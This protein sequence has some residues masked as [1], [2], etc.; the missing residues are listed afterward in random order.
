MAFPPEW[1][2]L[3]TPE[4]MGFVAW[5][6]SPDR[7]GSDGS[8]GLNMAADGIYVYRIP[9][10]ERVTVTRIVT[11]FPYLLAGGFVANSGNRLGLYTVT[12][13]RIVQS[14][15]MAAT[16]PGVGVKTGV[17][18]PTELTRGHYYVAFGLDV[19]SGGPRLPTQ[20]Y[21][22]NLGLRGAGYGLPANQP[23]SGVT[24]DT[25]ADMVGGLPVQFKLPVAVTAYHKWFALAA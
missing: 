20:N 11:Y 23:H 12:G 15:D 8:N 13:E 18:A 16:Y 24:A 21:V 6:F 5:T 4:D 3:W 25:A 2:P 22:A 1:P 14:Q 7:Q 17:I 19:T 10:R 9:I